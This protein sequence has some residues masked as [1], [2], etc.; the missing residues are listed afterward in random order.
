MQVLTG[1]TSCV[2]KVLF[3]KNGNYL[4]TYSGYFYGYLGDK[5]IKIW[6][7]MSNSDQK[8]EKWMLLNE[9][10]KNETPL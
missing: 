5:T 6:M 10:S 4:A 1:H 3:S 2:T 8:Y 7:K 9:I